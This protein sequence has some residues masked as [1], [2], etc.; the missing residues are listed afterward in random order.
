MNKRGAEFP[1]HATQ[2]VDTFRRLVNQLKTIRS[3]WVL[4][5]IHEYQ[6]VRI[7]EVGQPKAIEQY[8][9]PKDPREKHQ[10]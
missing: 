9:E 4:V 2:R 8:L 10:P 6:V 1:I 7:A 5:Q 3:G